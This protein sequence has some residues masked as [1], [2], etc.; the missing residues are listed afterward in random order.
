MGKYTSGFQLKKCSQS[1]LEHAVGTQV[2]KKAVTS[3]RPQEL[4]LCPLSV[5]PPQG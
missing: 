5:I 2:K 1:E 3:P 4:P